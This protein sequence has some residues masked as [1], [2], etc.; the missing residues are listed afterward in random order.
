MGKIFPAVCREVALTA[1]WDA[2]VLLLLSSFDHV[3]TMNA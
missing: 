2:H 1:F 3:A